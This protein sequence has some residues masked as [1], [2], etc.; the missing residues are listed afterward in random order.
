MKRLCFGPALK[1]VWANGPGQL[2]PQFDTHEGARGVARHA[3]V[4][5]LFHIANHLC[6]FFGSIVIEAER[7]VVHDNRDPLSDFV[8][9]FATPPP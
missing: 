9:F 5:R 6:I 4:M 3:R 2:S 7:I 8:Y 1:N